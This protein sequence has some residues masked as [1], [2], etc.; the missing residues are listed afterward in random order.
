V[1][2]NKSRWTSYCR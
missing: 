2:Y 1:W